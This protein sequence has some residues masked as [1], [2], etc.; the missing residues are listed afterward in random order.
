MSTEALEH[1]TKAA[2]EIHRNRI[3]LMFESTN[4]NLRFKVQN[5]NGVR[6]NYHSQEKAGQ[7]GYWTF[8]QDRDS[9]AKLLDIFPDLQQGPKIASWWRT[10]THRHTKIM[11]VAGADDANLSWLPD[12]H[13]D[14]FQ[15]VSTRPYQR[16][17]IAHM[18]AAAGT[19]N[20]NQP[21]LG[22][23][24]ETLGAI[25]E[26]DLQFGAHLVIAP[27]TSLE[28]TWEAHLDRFN[29]GPYYTVT[30]PAEHRIRET[31]RFH[32]A[33]ENDEVIWVITN[34][35]TVR[36][37]PKDFNSILWDSVTID[38]FDR[39]GLPNRKTKG[40]EAYTSLQA[41]K[42][43]LLSGTPIHGK[44]D[45]LWGPLHFLDPVAFASYNTWVNRWL[46][47]EEDPF[48]GGRR[49][50]GIQ[51]GREDAFWDHLRPWL[52]RRTKAE[53]RK[54][55][56]EKMWF[57]VWCEMGEKQAA[58]Y[59][60]MATATEIR[61]EE[62]Q[63]NAQNVLALY[64]RLKQF[65]NARCTV[66]K[67]V[68]RAGQEPELKVLPTDDSCK[69][70]MLMEKLA[71]RGIGKGETNVGDEQAII[72]TQFKTYANMLLEYLSER[73][74]GGVAIISG[75]VPRYKRG[76]VVR[77]FAD[78]KIRLAILV[79][80]A[81]GVSIEF[82]GAESAHIMDETWAPD[83]QEQAEDRAHRF[84]GLTVYTYRTRGTI[85]QF[86]QNKNID[87]A[88]INTLVLDYRRQG[89]IRAI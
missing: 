36:N 87:K 33:W 40:F 6:F 22:K 56:P 57:D 24:V 13:P 3:A 2:V 50:M 52:I 8:P 61:I 70:P 53:V 75:D 79:T 30:A 55:L 68:S 51:Y 59:K 44:P 71:E 38:E 64:T 62:E 89:L 80:K 21:S 41:K 17:D 7:S 45:K 29:I 9:M 32:K 1:K 18:A 66:K 85:E 49:I 83:D 16:A 78:K 10:E 12:N 35:E 37:N 31:R 67:I 42:K 88:A 86:I 63:L 5:I 60:K 46:I 77:D 69:L 54:D 15:F 14:M 26:A 34:F 82:D 27:A 81:G 43:F 11:S 19:M 48:S 58:Q 28:P 20:A 65:A 25:Y 39:S 4:R 23:T 72:I 84:T 74:E 73:I 47:T 76:Q